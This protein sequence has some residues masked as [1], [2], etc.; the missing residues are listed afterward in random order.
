[1]AHLFYKLT[2][3]YFTEEILAALTEFKKNAHPPPPNQPIHMARKHVKHHVER[4]LKFAVN[5]EN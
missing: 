4:N 5:W 1:M 2:I 3:S